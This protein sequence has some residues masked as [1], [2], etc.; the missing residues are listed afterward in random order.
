M[1]HQSDKDRI[2]H[3]IEH[4]PQ[5]LYVPDDTAALMRIKPSR[6][7]DLLLWVRLESNNVSLRDLVGMEKHELVELLREETKEPRWVAA[8]LRNHNLHFPALEESRCDGKT[9]GTVQTFMRQ[10][11]GCECAI[12]LQ[13]YE[14]FC[15]LVFLPCGHIFHSECV[16]S[17]LVAQLDV[18][19]TQGEYPSCPSCRTPINKFVPSTPFRLGEH[20][21]VKRKRES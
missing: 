21:S 18:C 16:K 3:R 2:C 11:V 5:D 17:W 7:K 14:P 8:Q 9:I 20:A 1:Y 6:L 15:E 19:A 12:C 10:R 4:F 13:D